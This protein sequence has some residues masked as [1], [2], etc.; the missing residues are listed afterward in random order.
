MKIATCRSY[1]AQ[2]VNRAAVA[3]QDGRSF[4]KVYYVSIVGRPD[5]EKYE[6]AF[7]PLDPA[8]FEDKLKSLPFEGVGFLTAFPH[9]T[10]LFTFSPASEILML[11]SAFNTAT[12]QPIPLERERGFYEFAC[13]AE[14]AIAAD[15]YGA[16]ATAATVSDYL[17]FWS[18]FK[19]GPIA[20]HGK[21]KAYWEQQEN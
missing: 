14:A 2:V 7:C 9:I 16:W 8:Q 13:L 5:S 12:F 10:K 1:H 17:G 3:L 15:E 4:L 18:P 20:E 6:W 19:D 11:V 21:L